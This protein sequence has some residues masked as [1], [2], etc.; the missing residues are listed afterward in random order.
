MFALAI[1]IFRKA[2]C[3]DN[4]SQAVYK[5]ANVK[6]VKSYEFKYKR[7]KK[8]GKGELQFHESYN[9]SGLLIKSLFYGLPGGGE[10]KRE[11]YYDFNEN[12]I[13]EFNYIYDSANNMIKKESMSSF[14]DTWNYLYDSL[15]NQTRIIWHYFGETKGS[16]F[17]KDTMEYNEQ[18]K[19]IK[20]TRY[21]PSGKVY[22]YLVY[23]YDTLGN[24]IAYS[25]FENNRPTDKWTYTYD[26][27]GNKIEFNHFDYYKNDITISTKSY[28]NDKNLAI[29]RI[30]KSYNGRK[31]STVKYEFRYE[32]Y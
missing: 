25:R 19:L 10:F 9:K 4:S 32:F 14:G 28:Y 8:R 23:E 26:L 12:Q 18:N 2:S 30:V 15:G 21:R 20:N 7:G 27:N 31:I 29:S 22:F 3:Q 17:F 11:Y 5:K 1:F 13:S 16:Y 24:L 6:Y